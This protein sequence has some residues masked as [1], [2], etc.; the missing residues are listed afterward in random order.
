MKKKKFFKNMKRILL[1]MLCT[2]TLFFSMPKKTNA[3]TIENFV[4][5]M[6]KIPDMVMRL[7]NDISGESVSNFKIKLN[8]K[9]WS[10]ATK[11]S[12]Y[13]F[14]VTPYDIFTSGLVYQRAEDFDGNLGDEKYVRIPVLD[15]NFFRDDTG[16]ANYANSSA[17]I[18]RPVV[19]N[20][21][22]SLRNLV[23]VMMMVILLY[24]GIRIVVSTAV[25]DQVKYKQWLVDW[26]VGICLL[27]IMQ[28]I[29]SFLMN[30]NEMIVKML[31]DNK[32]SSYYISLSK[33]GGGVETEDAINAGSNAITGK[34]AVSAYYNDWGDVKEAATIGSSTY[35]PGVR[36]FYL[37]HL[38]VRNKDNGSDCFDFDESTG[39]IH[40]ERNDWASES[41]N[42]NVF[43]NA[44]IFRPA[45]EGIH[46]AAKVVSGGILGT[47]GAVAGGVV[48]S[49]FSPAG[50][51]VGG[52]A[53]FSTFS[54]AGWSIASAIVGDDD[55][56]SWA[57]K[58]VYRCN[59]PEFCRTIT[60]FGSK[61]VWIYR[62]SGVYE[63]YTEN[64]DVDKSNSRFGEFTIL[65]ILLVLET[66]IFFYTYLKRVFKLAFYTMIA[67]LIAFM[68]PLDKLGDGKAQAF[69]TWFK[70]YMFN[71]LVQPL[72]LLLY[73]VFIYAASEL[74]R[75]N[76]IYAIGAY[77]YMIA[78]EKFFKKIFGF[79]KAPGGTPG[80]AGPGMAHAVG[81][82]LEKLGGFGPPKMG[83]KG[84]SD[85]KGKSK[86]KLARNPLA[87]GWGGAPTTGGMPSSGGRRGSRGIPGGGGIPIGGGPSGG[88][89]SGGIPSSG[90]GIPGG[91]G[92]LPAGVR[93]GGR[94]I[95]GAVSGLGNS[96]ARKFSGNK[97]GT[98]KELATKKGI[99]A[100]LGN[101][102][103]FG[104]KSAVRV[105]GGV[106]GA[107]LGVAAGLA[108]GAVTSILT[109][110]DNIGKQMAAG[111]IAGTN[112]GQQF[113][114]YLNDKGEAFIEEGKDRAAENDPEYAAELEAQR[115]MD[116]NE[117]MTAEQRDYA[118][119]VLYNGAKREEIEQNI[120]K[121]KSQM[122]AGVSPE[123][124][125]QRFHYNKVDLNNA[126]EYEKSVNNETRTILN[127]S[128][129]RQHIESNISND[130]IKDKQKELQA[131]IQQQ[132]N[133]AQE[134]LRKA[135]DEQKN[136]KTRS[137][138][139]EINKRI[140]GCEKQI[141]AYET[142]KS[143]ITH[144]VAKE[145]LIKDKARAES[146]RRHQVYGKWS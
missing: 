30:V 60:T 17:N 3:G 96:L 143:K 48:G 121:L 53:G 103:K 28:Y 130:D 42:G 40:V 47:I 134:A 99:K 140:E 132:I 109:G 12:A 139:S 55:D 97:A 122:N 71:V 26:V 66:C 129:Q 57:D 115:I 54:A 59:L 86:V 117:N 67:P 72:H 137:E 84:G 16:I 10:S 31:G 116:N 4:D 64:E 126:E 23:L 135:K 118:A 144:E 32:E 81:H 112:R 85:E 58:V 45:D 83:G 78:A 95:K 91:S 80:L 38:D 19:S 51:A 34:D 141:E 14:D 41:K 43:I 120:D 90:G 111:A 125:A 6:L 113:G 110:E 50:T 108:T 74:V 8:L 36:L 63:A 114:Q 73:T 20:V 127:D 13:N 92:R 142:Q 146:E 22:K 105:G 62:G 79:E 70:E 107:G 77:G 102:V 61:Y 89:P 136:A 5:L 100:T 27:L 15:I 21:Y 39:E 82:G 33:L 75:E 119:K 87:P 2:I 133:E 138:Q 18:L 93:R 37:D 49:V 25:A 101:A 88:G 123:V 131:P 29:M 76:M 106:V 46:T 94:V 1:I 68:Y 98:L 11:G 128:A 56:D 65:Y 44:R 7:F 104:A 35:D 69:N 124:A 9:G 145:S 52:V 24:I